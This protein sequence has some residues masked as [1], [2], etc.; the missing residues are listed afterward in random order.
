MD[1]KK[2]QMGPLSEEIK[3]EEGKLKKLEEEVS[4]LTARIE[5]KKAK[6]LKTLNRAQEYCLELEKLTGSRRVGEEL[7]AQWE[8]AG[9]PED[10]DRIEEDLDGLQAESACIGNINR[11]V[12]EEYLR[13]KDSVS[14]L[15]ESIAS[16]GSDTS[17]K[18][19]DIASLKAEWIGRL[20]DLVERLDSKFRRNFDTMG[21]AGQIQL[22]VPD[23]RNNF[24]DD[25][26]I[27]IYVKYRENVRLAKLT[28]HMQSGGERSVATAL[29]MMS[30]QELTQVPFRC[31]DEINQGMDAVNERKVFDIL[32][33]TSSK[34]DSSA[35]YFLLTP[36]LL[37]DLRFNELV[38]VHVVYNGV[39]MLQC[40]P[41]SS[42][43][44]LKKARERGV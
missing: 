17:K 39:H 11:S 29:Y 23:E 42:D 6:A 14:S 12:V 34:E 28:P 16:K 35:Q 31:V 4:K 43:K 10:V 41:I 22:K 19:E 2:L 27:E 21:Y 26:G 24:E 32:I 3:S 1:R 36:K 44:F 38:K 20:N 30:L 9:V 25:Y 18:Q 15:E 8:E 13:L 5:E 7:K 33:N 37:P 40:P